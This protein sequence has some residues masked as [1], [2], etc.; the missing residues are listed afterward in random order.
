[1]GSWDT[2]FSRPYGDSPYAGYDRVDTPPFLFR[3]ALDRR[4]LPKG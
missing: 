1:M 2:D 4:L 3:G